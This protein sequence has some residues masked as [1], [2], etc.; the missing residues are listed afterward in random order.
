MRGPGT[1]LPPPPAPAAAPPGRLL[2]TGAGLSHRGLVRAVNEDAILIDPSGA[3][4][5]IA[6]GMGGHG[7]GDLAADLVIDAFARMPHGPGGRGL[8]ADAFAAAHAEVRRRARAD[9]LGEI[10]AT[11]VALL[12]EDGSAILAWAGDSRAYRLRR[13]ALERLS[14]DHSLVQELLD[15]G[16]IGPAEAETHPQRHVVTR[17]VGAGD[18]AHPDFADL[19]LAEGD[20]YLLCSDGL[21]RCV[22][23]ARIATLLAAAPDPAQ[24]CRALVEAALAGGA[25]DNVSAI[26]VAIGAPAAD[27]PSTDRPSTDGPATDGAPR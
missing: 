23:D 25:P 22:P 3:L 10:G 19:A 1:N 2:A 9:R 7:H 17:A 13:G 21:T 15:R 4:W 11:A 12:V 20:L 26:V 5:A 6:D 27:G 8:L 16:E 24:A 14:H 18:P